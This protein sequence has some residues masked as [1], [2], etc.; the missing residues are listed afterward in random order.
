MVRLRYCLFL[1][2]LAFTLTGLA[3]AQT[4]ITTGVIQ[5]TTLDQSGAVIVDADI[6]AKNLDT[7]TE[8]TLKT[9]GDGRFVFLSLRPGRYSVTASKKGFSK[10]IQKDL[11]LTVGQA[12]SLKVTLKV[13]AVG[14]TIEV[15]DTPTIEPTESVS[16]TTLNEIA[17]NATPVLG[18]KFEDLLTLTPG[19]AV[20]QGPDGDEISFPGP[21][22]HFNH[23]TLA[24]CASHKRV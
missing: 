10:V 23:V 7:Q 9:D 11:D 12:I 18:R 19:V 13:S 5:G 8:T 24:A 22:G 15:T 20:V 14:E 6:T 4:Q 3:P 1:L 21:R 16:S 2:F 17:V